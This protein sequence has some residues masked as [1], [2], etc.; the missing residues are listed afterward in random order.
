VASN[1]GLGELGLVT[2]SQCVRDDHAMIVY[3]CRTA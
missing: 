3:Y 1:Y 2:T